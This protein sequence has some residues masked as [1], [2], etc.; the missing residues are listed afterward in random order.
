MAK[1]KQI[2]GSQLDLKDDSPL[3]MRR[4][5]FAGGELQMTGSTAALGH[6]TAPFGFYQKNLRNGGGKV[7]MIGSEVDL[8]RTPHRGWESHATPMSIS[9]LTNEEAEAGYPRNGGKVK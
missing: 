1:E 6:E 2:I 9:S 5:S 7:T 8:S 3:D 4:E